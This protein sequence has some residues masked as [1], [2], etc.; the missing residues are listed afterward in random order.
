MSIGSEPL[1]VPIFKV[2]KIDTKTLES[3]KC[4]FRVYSEWKKDYATQNVFAYTKGTTHADSFIVFT[5]HY[6]HLG[7]LGK[8]NYFPGANDNASGIAMLNELARHYGDS[9]QQHKYSIVFIAFAAEEAGLLGSKYFTQ[10]PAIDLKAIKF[11]INM[12]IMGTG[13]ESI[14]VVNATKHPAEY[15]K[16]D[17]INSAQHLVPAVTKR[18]NAA[19]S[20]HYYFSQK[21]V[22]ALFIY[23]NGEQKAYHDV[24]DVPKN[25]TL[26]YFVP[27]LKLLTT[28]C[29]QL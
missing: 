1:S 15:S 6:D 17:S 19:N 28:F 7:H 3:G 29:D 8:H 25:L 12:D 27:I 26:D 11:L 16:L 23:T 22:P 4:S 9:S 21:G 10:H 20:D 14:T 13:D 18:G 5:A 2:G 24:F